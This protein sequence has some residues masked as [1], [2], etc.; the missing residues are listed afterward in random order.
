MLKLYRTLSFSFFAVFFF[1]FL[2]LCSSKSPAQVFQSVTNLNNLTVSAI[3]GEKPQSKVWTYAGRWWAVMPNSSGTQIWRLDGTTWTSVLNIDASTATYADCKV[4]GSVTHILLYKGTSSS[5]VSVEY[6]P[7]THTYQLWT[8]RT[9]TVSITLDAGVETASIDIDRN[10]RMWLASAGTTT[11]NVRWSD[12]PYSGWS[13]PISIG[14]GVNDDDIC[15]VTSFD[16]KIGV[17]WS[18]QNT[19]RFGFKYHVDGTDPATWTADE[20]PA[21]QSA[22]NVGLGMADDH[23]NLAVASDGTIYAAVKTSYDTPG[24]PRIAMLI[25]RPSGAWDNLYSVDEGGTRGIVIL[26]EAAGKVEVIFTASDAGGNILYRESPISNISFGSTN[27][28][29][30][31]GTFNNATSTKQNYLNEIVIIAGNGSTA[32]GVLGSNG[33]YALNFDGINDPAL[34]DHVNC[35]NSSAADITSAITLE[36]WVRSDGQ[37]TQTIV[38]KNTSTAGYELSLSNNTGAGLPQNFFFRLNGSG[39][40]TYRVNSTSYYPIDGTWAHVAA[41]YDGSVMKLYVNGVQEGGDIP[42]PA[43]IIPATTSNLVI[44][45]EPTAL[46]TKSFN[47]SIDEVRVWN[48]ART[49]Q[50]ILDNYNKEITSSAGLVGR[51][52]MNEGTGTAT[53]NS[54]LG[55]GMTGTLMNGTVVGNGP[56][57]VPGAPFNISLTSAP[58]APTLVSPANTATG[59][60]ILPTLSWNTSTGATSYQV[61]VSTTSNFSTTV[62]DQSG[63]TSTSTSISP[64]LLNNTVYYWRVN[65]SNIIGTSSWS[66]TWSFTTAAVIPPIE[67]N[68]AGYALDFDGT[69][70]YVNCGNNTSVQITGTAITMEAWIKPTKVGTMAILKKCDPIDNTPPLNGKGYELSCGNSGVL[71]VRLNGNDLARTNS[72]ITYPTAGGWM[73]VAATYDGA[74]I[75]IYINGVLDGTT[76][77][78]GAIVNSPNI[79]EIANDPSTAARFFQGS[80]DEVRLWNV[81]RSDLEIKGNMTKKLIGNESGLVGYWRFNETSG[82]SMNDETSN[83]NDGTMVDMDPL[84]DHVWSGASLG[85]ASVSDYNSVGGYSATLLSPDGDAITATTTSAGITGLQLYRVDDNP[86]R[87][88]ST[89]PVG[90]TLSPLRYWGVKAIGSGT[91]TYTVVYNY[92]GHPGITPANENMLDLALR[93][94]LADNSWINL[95]AAIDTTNNTLT[96]TG[97]TGTEYTLA[98]FGDDPLPVELSSFTAKMVNQKVILNWSTATEVNNYGFDI[99]RRLISDWEI[100]GFVQG[101]GNS[102]SPKNYSFADENKLNGNL[103]Y[104]LK[105]IDNDGKINYSKVIEVSS[106]PTEYALY[107]NY[108]NPFNPTTSI[109]FTLVKDNLVNINVYSVLGELVTNITNKVYP[110]GLHK[111][112]FNSMNIP[113]GVYLY[114][115]KVGENGSEFTSVKKMILLK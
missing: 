71:F 95:V 72:V 80:I 29:M 1:S 97:M 99:E 66:S 76:A 77:Y 110:A 112:E 59:I 111:L 48:V 86:L 68:G 40:D 107:Q 12:T 37:G 78:T 54:G 94:N 13:S 83:N 57:W 44:G 11:I 35:Q 33:S 24:Y 39:S 32:V 9:T 50:E 79:L 41:T 62:F 46:G 19:Q 18:N 74:N 89:T 14:S 25:R 58:F 100:I 84:T 105:Q 113:S 38:K 64:A 45:T 82:S 73:H 6:V 109:A 2:F 36:A 55:I 51:W 30:S 115:I 88:N 81:V 98:T 8:T 21:S 108:P 42:G 75:R 3:T 104:R 101:N 27:T 67:N 10:G 26:N 69:N 92:S 34:V 23:I 85:D 56:L 60:N 28:L 47:G 87:T 22:L 53:S 31:G 65:A 5:L 17:L 15:A 52:G 91:P 61:Q 63:I 90:V 103:Q 43:S 4:V 7:A 106:M 70:D 96:L 102:N 93:D 16:G 20:V 114:Q 49:A